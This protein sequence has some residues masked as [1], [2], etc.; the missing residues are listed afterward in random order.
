[1]DNRQS[2]ADYTI[3]PQLREFLQSERQTAYYSV[4]SDQ[5]INSDEK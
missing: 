3:I 5:E 4:L 1:M 2:K